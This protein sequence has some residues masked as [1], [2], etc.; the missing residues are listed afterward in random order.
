M[1]AAVHKKWLQ[2]ML[3]FYNDSAAHR[4]PDAGQMEVVERRN[5]ALLLVSGPEADASSLCV[6]QG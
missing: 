6:V 1:S 4:L 3:W 2:T 5:V